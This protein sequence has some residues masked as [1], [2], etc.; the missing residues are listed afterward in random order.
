MDSKI[1]LP[2]LAAMLADYS[3]LKRKLCDD[4]L[5]ELFSV[6]GNELAN[7]RQVKIKGFGSF[8]LMP[9]EARKSVNVTTGEAF[10][11]PAHHKVVFTPAKELAALA[12]SPFEVFEVVELDDSITAEELDNNFETESDN[13]DEYIINE[14]ADSNE[15]TPE[16]TSEA[17]P[18]APS[19]NK[20]EEI[21]ADE[22]ESSIEDD[23]PD[24]N[25]STEE[26]SYQ[27]Y[28]DVQ[29]DAS[30]I[31]DTEIFY[32]SDIEEEIKRRRRL[33][34]HGFI[35]GFVCATVIFICVLFGIY[36]CN[37]SSV[38]NWKNRTTATT[39]TKPIYEKQHCETIADST[40]NKTSSDATTENNID[41]K[42]DKN[43]ELAQT[44]PTMPSDAKV[45]K[46]YDT[47][48]K[49]RYLTTMA[50]QHYGNYNLWP[51]IYEENK[52]ILGHPDRIKPGTKVVIPDL[53]KYGV[54]PSNPADIKKA[55]KMGI[56]IYARYQ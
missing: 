41:A 43:D 19:E 18:E 56:D 7:D 42:P 27:D 15:V 26:P 39:E 13:H 30:P 6:V 52:K 4:F 2:K 48:T 32:E 44:A 21:A 49:T 53:S 50:K 54:D 34:T 47:I 5:R 46:V 16:V 31:E 33:K 22:E 10:E 8:K 12:N 37:L 14:K 55:K 45:A 25:I 23:A 38:I 1:T 51:Y 36:F 40:E 9:V 11:I 20:I 17:T 24:E 28:D 3:G 29:N 35:W